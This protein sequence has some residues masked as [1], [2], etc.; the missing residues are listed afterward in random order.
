MMHIKGCH[1]R[2]MCV[3]AIMGVVLSM[4]TPATV[5]SEPVSPI[6]IGLSAD[7]STVAVEG[8]IA[9]K[10]GATIA[11]NEINQQG[12][13]LGRPLALTVLDHRGNPSRGL[14][15]I[16]TLVVDKEVIAILSGVHTP[17]ALNQ[18]KA[19]HAHKIPFLIP[20]AAG[21]PVVDNGFEPNYVFR[22]SVRD[23][24]AGGFLVKKVADQGYKKVGLLL[25]RTGWGRSNEKSM[26]KAAATFGL[27]VTSVQWFHWGD[28]M[29]AQHLSELKGSKAE[30]ILLV[31]NAPEGASAV[32]AVA[33]LP[34][35]D[36]FP[37]YSHWG[38]TGGNFIEQVGLE[39][40]QSVDL[41]FLQTFSFL[42]PDNHPDRQRFVISSY[43]QW[44]DAVTAA[45]IPSAVGV[46]HAYDLVH[47]LAKA[48]KQAGVVD[49]VKVREQL[50]QLEPY[51]GLVKH[52]QK[53]FT[54]KNHEALDESDYIL[55]RFTNRGTIEPVHD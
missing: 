9:I 12:G 49:K 4:M 47:L 28:K 30:A 21:T 10:R 29:F 18:L 44:D 42:N 45:T 41:N 1:K 6:L 38:I 17:V 23:E 7:V 33:A 36:R 54:P 51:Q 11:I 37:I 24:W 43:K 31:A 39:T 25:E 5:D 22:L 14:D 35:A 46:A 26:L 34:E 8:G 32:K 3:F 40:L 2:F 53:P 50:E 19:I 55:A 13:V 52:Y 15:D 48:L 16:E 27:E 20:W